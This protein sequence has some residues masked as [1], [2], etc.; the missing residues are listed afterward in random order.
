MHKHDWV[1]SI[2]MNEVG[3]KNPWTYPWTVMNTSTDLF[4]EKNLKSG[5]SIKYKGVHFSL[6]FNHREKLENTEMSNMKVITK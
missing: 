6:F 2:C 3:M 4:K 1:I 5:Q